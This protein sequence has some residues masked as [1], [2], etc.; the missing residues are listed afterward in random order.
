MAALQDAKAEK[1]A[2]VTAIS[3][4]TFKVMFDRAPNWFDVKTTKIKCVG[5][6]HEENQKTI[7]STFPNNKNLSETDREC[8][9]VSTRWHKDQ[10]GRL[11]LDIESIP[12]FRVA[13]TR[14]C[15]VIILPMLYD[16]SHP[17][18][19]KNPDENKHREQCISAIY[20]VAKKVGWGASLE[21][22]TAS[23]RMTFSWFRP[24]PPVKK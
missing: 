24:K 4:A 1:E 8:S 14:E 15:M 23:E 7:D 16:T 12:N 13:D 3:P 9:V 10:T 19:K 17:V 18:Y 20:D 22:R 21:L 11:V 6:S 2:D 5:F